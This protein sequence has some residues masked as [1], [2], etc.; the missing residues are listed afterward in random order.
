MESPYRWALHRMYGSPFAVPQGSW[1]MRW[2]HSNPT[3]LLFSSYN[4]LLTTTPLLYPAVIGLLALP[5]WP[6]HRR[7]WP[8]TVL[9]LAALYV[10]G[11]VWDWWGEASFSSRRLTDFSCLF[12]VATAMVLGALFRWAERAPR[13]TAGALLVFPIT[14]GVLWNRGAMVSEAEGRTRQM[15]ARSAPERWTPVMHFAGQALWRDVGPGSDRFD[16]VGP[17]EYF[18]SG[19]S[20]ATTAAPDRGRVLL[21]SGRVLLPL[22]D[23]TLGAVEVEAAPQADTTVRLR[24]NGRDLGS[25]V[26]SPS[27]PRLRFELPSGAARVGI[28][29]LRWEASAPVRLRWMHLVERR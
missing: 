5:F 26:A 27:S 3:G 9:F 20:G 23:D 7:L 21:G 1:Y 25:S 19:F 15:G 2:G 17:D 16:F 24:W 10:N 13:Q 28:N 12:V 8:A 11:A 22:F 4:G 6:R 18:A 29:E 14:L